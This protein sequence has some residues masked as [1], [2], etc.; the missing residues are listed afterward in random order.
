VGDFG[1]TYGKIRR[2]YHCLMKYFQNLLQHMMSVNKLINKHLV[3]LLR[4]GGGYLNN[5]IVVCTAFVAT[6]IVF[7]GCK[8]PKLKK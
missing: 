7:N 1:S 6:A 8:F 2:K 5:K 4:E 3:S